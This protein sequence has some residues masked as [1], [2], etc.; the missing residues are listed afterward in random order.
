[1]ARRF[2]RLTLHPV[3]GPSF[4]L[5]RSDCVFFPSEEAPQKVQAGRLLEF[6]GP[7]LK[8]TEHL[9]TAGGLLRGLAGN[10]G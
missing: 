2:F 9:G 6:L 3:V 10:E 5:V 4:Y 7:T 8:C 1:M